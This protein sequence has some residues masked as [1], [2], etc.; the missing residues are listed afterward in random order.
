[1]S[2]DSFYLVLGFVI[3]LLF[4]VGVIVG[5]YAQRWLTAPTTPVIDDRMVK[6]RLRGLTA[7]EP[8]M[9]AMARTDEQLAR[10]NQ[11]YKEFYKLSEAELSSTEP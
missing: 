3:T 8:Y 2:E 4:F 11:A 1:M 10:N 6:Y 7:V 9:Q 5:A